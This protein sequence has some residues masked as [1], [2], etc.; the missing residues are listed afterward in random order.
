[1]RERSKPGV[2]PAE[3]PVSNPRE[4]QPQRGG[5]YSVCTAE[6]FLKQQG[7][8]KPLYLEMEIKEDRLLMPS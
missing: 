7:L 3:V 6:D 8:E 4:E 5:S 1:V 2:C